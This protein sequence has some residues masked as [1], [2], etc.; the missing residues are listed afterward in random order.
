MKRK[1]NTRP[2]YLLIKK[3]F[4]FL[5]FQFHEQFHKRCLTTIY[6]GAFINTAVYKVISL[7]PGNYVWNAFNFDTVDTKI[8]W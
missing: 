2:T 1:E 4:Q 6:Q 3:H 7:L 5:S 8:N